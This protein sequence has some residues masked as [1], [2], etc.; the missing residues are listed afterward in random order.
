MSGSNKF[1]YI[2]SGIVSIILG[3]FLLLNPLINLFAFTWVMSIIFFA[4][5]ISGIINYFRLPSAM[6]SGWHL[7]G[8]IINALFGSI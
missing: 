8:G 2:L 6:R 4:N 3:I 1:F 5:A 7:I